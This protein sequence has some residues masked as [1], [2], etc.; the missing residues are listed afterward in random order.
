MESHEP[1]M[2]SQASIQTLPCG[3]NGMG[4]YIL[5]SGKNLVRGGGRQVFLEAYFVEIKEFCPHTYL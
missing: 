5:F 4:R 3:S 2:I 1:D